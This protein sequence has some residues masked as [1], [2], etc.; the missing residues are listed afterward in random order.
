MDRSGVGRGAGRC[1]PV[2]VTG[3]WAVLAAWLPVALALQVAFAQRSTTISESAEPAAANATES[4]ASAS[5]APAAWRALR[6]PQASSPRR[7]AAATDIPL[8]AG[9]TFGVAM[10]SPN[11]TTPL[12]RLGDIAQ[13]D[14]EMI[15]AITTVDAEGVVSQTRVEAR[16][17]NDQPLNLDIKRRVPVEDL[18]GSRLQILGFH[19]DEP[20]EIEGTTS[21]GPSLA[22]MRDLAATGRAEYALRDFSSLP[23]QS[24]ELRRAQES[25]ILFP[26]LMNGERVELP[27]TYATADLYVND[28]FR[29][30]EH[31]FLD[32]P[33]HPVT[34]F[35]AVRAENAGL[36]S[37]PMAVRQ[38]VRIDF[39]SA[40]DEALE[41]ALST[42]CRVE[43]PGVY[44][45]F[46][47]DTLNPQ[48]S[49]ALEAIADMLAR[50]PDWQIAIEGHTDNVGR[51][52]Y[53]ADLSARRA[54][55]VQRAL[56]GEL[57]IAPTRL[58]S[59]GFGES[60]PVE[61][62]DTIEGRARNRR[63][64]LVRDCP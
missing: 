5:D 49:R 43:V 44:F 8:V 27:A 17:Q 26:I 64:E 15:V 42:E 12:A 29:S 9:L 52:A 40:D 11:E 50:Q 24:G 62:N 34:L 30:W 39:P 36:D 45:D 10:H 38:I 58:T 16:D 7:L 33:V 55:A 3:R 1:R 28:R 21:L 53:N 32:H 19:T 47:R 6:R 2:S 18:A 31:I 56:V 4:E 14:Y 37:E 60:R 61:S 59:E 41:S 57:G 35:F 25:P 63:V 46:N 48:S 20:L 54:A 23:T 22:V 51:D 13:G